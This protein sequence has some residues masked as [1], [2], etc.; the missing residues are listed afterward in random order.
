[1]NRRTLR[2]W[3]A[4]RTLGD[5]GE[6]MARWITGELDARPG[7][8]GET[9]IDTGELTQLCVDLCRAGFVTVGSQSAYPIDGLYDARAFIDGFATPAVVERLRAAC[10][11]TSIHVYESPVPTSR[12]L[13]RASDTLPAVVQRSNDV[14]HLAVAYPLTRGDLRLMWSTVSWHEL[15]YVKSVS[16]AGYEAIKRS[17]F[18]TVVDTEWNSDEV[19]ISTLRSRFLNVG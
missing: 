13:R 2:T 3:L 18:V 17:R 9:D 19:L 12:A 8:D 4:A 15:W 5:I 11:G 7:Y 14:V 16:H 10:R 1:M 6:L